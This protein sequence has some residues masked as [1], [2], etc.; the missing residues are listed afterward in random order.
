MANERQWQEL[1][2]RDTGA[3]VDIAISR[4]ARRNSLDFETWAEL[5]AIMAEVAERDEVRVVTLTGE[6]DSFSSGVDFEWIARSTQT[7]LRE[8]PSFIR[9]WSGVTDAFER[10]AQPTIAVVNGPA[11]GGGCELALACDLRICSDR[12]IFA[13][14]QM[15]MGI[16]PDTGGTSRLAKAAGSAL[17]KDMILTGRVLDAEEALRFGL[18]SR[19]VP[20]GEL[21]GV[22][23]EM[24]DAIAALP[25][26]STYYAN[27]AVD[28]GALLDSR[29]AADLEAIA[30]Q[31]MF[32][33][34]EVTERIDAFM[35]S[36]GLKGMSGER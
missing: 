31:V 6:G 15:R 10:V 14:P 21:A 11:V 4:P 35:R 7:E 12:A 23:D 26:P 22:A 30:D 17:A 18:V 8:Y 34:A 9:R 5:A 2:V 20:H 13:M 24:A 28:V 27:F 25:W 16:V 32:R 1:T 36:K 3:R 29:R 19:V 33:Q